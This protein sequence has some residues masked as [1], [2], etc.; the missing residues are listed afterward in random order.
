MSNTYFYRR[1]FVKNSNKNLDSCY[2]FT[3]KS[4]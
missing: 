4:L 3:I 2:T 1:Y